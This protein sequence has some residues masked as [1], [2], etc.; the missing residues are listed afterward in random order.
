VVGW[1]GGEVVRELTPSTEYR[2]LN[3]RADV[4]YLIPPPQYL[5]TS[6]PHDH[7]PGQSFWSVLAKVL[8]EIGLPKMHFT[9]RTGLVSALI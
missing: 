1:W 5:T 3:P 4:Q 2:V 9:P 8:S 7:Y 6:L